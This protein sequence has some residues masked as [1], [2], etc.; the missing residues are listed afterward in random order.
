MLGLGHIDCMTSSGTLLCDQG[1]RSAQAT[2]LTIALGVGVM[3][4]S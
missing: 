3:V 2:A 4:S 1:L